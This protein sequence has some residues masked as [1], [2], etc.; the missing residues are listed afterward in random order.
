M[1]T[2]SNFIKAL[3]PA[4][5][6]GD[7]GDGFTT[8]GFATKVGA[9]PN[10]DFCMLYHEDM[11]TS[12]SLILTQSPARGRISPLQRIRGELAQWLEQRNHNPLVPSSNLGFATKNTRAY[13]QKRKPFV[14]HG[15]LLGHLGLTILPRYLFFSYSV[16][17]RQHD[18][19]HRG[20]GIRPPK[21][22]H[23]WG[24]LPSPG[25]DYYSP[26]RNM[27]RK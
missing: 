23:W 11:P 10:F 12:P 3:Y 18:P 21:Y 25:G 26:S 22:R 2:I 14:F 9:Q 24:H 4:L 20:W 7:E 8:Y 16:G 15:T 17:F 6:P 19:M 1:I 5:K 27:C 13:V